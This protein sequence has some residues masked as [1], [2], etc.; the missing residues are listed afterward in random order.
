MEGH[1]RWK[2][3]I[4]RC[5]VKGVYQVIGPLSNLCKLAP[6]HTWE[7]RA[8]RAGSEEPSLMLPI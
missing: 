8:L 2:D 1:K 7:S 5:D 3:T 6:P 4:E